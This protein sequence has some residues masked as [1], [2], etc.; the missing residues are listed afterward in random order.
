MTRENKLSIV[1]AFGM[2]IFVGMLVADHFSIASH[3]EVAN[4][5]ATISTPPLAGTTILEPGDFIPEQTKANDNPAGDTI[6]VVQNDETLRTICGSFYGDSGLA[7]A[8]ASWNQITDANSIEKGQRVALPSRTSL[9]NAS[10]VFQETAIVEHTNTVLA[11]PTMGSYT[12][13]SGDTLS[14][15]SQKVMGTA[16]KTQLLIDLNKDVMPNP[17]RIRPGMTLRYP[18]QT[19]GA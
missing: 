15:I 16:K 11:T 13:K 6:H 3:R 9:V 19:N 2:L 10:F 18:L 17:N 1:I 4:L 12:V 5:G 7:N 8:V 14:E